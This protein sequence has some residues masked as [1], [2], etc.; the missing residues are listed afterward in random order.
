[1]R[2]VWLLLP[3]L[4]VSFAAPLGGTE[5]GGLIGRRELR[6]PALVLEAQTV[7]SGAAGRRQGVLF[8]T[9]SNFGGRRRLSTPAGSDAAGSVEP[10]SSETSSDDAIASLI[11][12]FGGVIH[13]KRRLDDDDAV[14]EEGDEL[15]AGPA[16]TKDSILSAG[17][18][19]KPS[20][21]DEGEEWMPTYGGGYRKEP[22]LQ[23][24]YKAL[25]SEP[26]FGSSV[27]SSIND[28]AVVAG[29]TRG[30]QD[31]AAGAAST[32]HTDSGAQQEKTP[33]EEATD[34]TAD[35]ED[36]KDKSTKTGDA[37]PTSAKD[38]LPVKLSEI[39]SSVTNSASQT[40][41]K[42]PVPSQGVQDVPKQISVEDDEEY[43]DDE[44]YED[45]EEHVQSNADKEDANKIQGDDSKPASVAPQVNKAP[46]TNAE[47]M[48]Y[49][50]EQKVGVF[51]ATP[52]ISQLTENNQ[53]LVTSSS[54]AVTPPQ[55]GVARA[56]NTEDSQQAKKLIPRIEEPASEQTPTVTNLPL[57]AVSA[58]L[59]A[60]SSVH[61]GMLNAEQIAESLFSQQKEISTGSSS[62]S[63]TKSP[64]LGTS[65]KSDFSNT[66]SPRLSVH[67]VADQ[68]L[69]VSPNNFQQENEQVVSN[70]SALSKAAID[71]SGLQ[72]GVV[73]NSGV[74]S[75]GDTSVTSEKS[76]EDCKD[77]SK[78]NNNNAKE[79]KTIVNV[80]DGSVL[81]RANEQD[82]TSG[83][84]TAVVHSND[85]S[86]QHSFI[87]PVSR[88]AAQ[89]EII[90]ALKLRAGK[91]GSSEQPNTQTEISG[92]KRPVSENSGVISDSPV[93]AA[94]LE[95]ASVPLSMSEKKVS[96]SHQ[97]AQNAVQ[98]AGAALMDHGVPSEVPKE[99]IQL[100]NSEGS[101]ELAVSESLIPGYG[102]PETVGVFYTLENV[103]SQGS[104]P[105]DTASFVAEAPAVRFSK[106]TNE[107]NETKFSE[108]PSNETTPNLS[109]KLAGK[110]GDLQTPGTNSSGQ[111][112]YQMA[113]SLGA[114]V[115]GIEPKSTQ[116]SVP[117]DSSTS[118]VTGTDSL[119]TAKDHKLP[120]NDLAEPI[121]SRPK[122]D[123]HEISINVTDGKTPIDVSG[124]VMT[125]S[126]NYSSTPSR[127]KPSTT[128]TDSTTGLVIEGRDSDAPIDVSGIAT[129][130]DTPADEKKT[131]SQRRT[132]TGGGIETM[133]TSQNE[134][135][136]PSSGSIAST[137]RK[138]DCKD[139]DNS[140]VDKS[141]HGKPVVFEATP[142]MKVTGA[143]SLLAT[144]G[145]VETSERTLGSATGDVYD[146]NITEQND[147][148][149][150]EP[151]ERRPGDLSMPS[152]GEPT[153]NE[154]KTQPK[155]SQGTGT[156]Y[157]VAVTFTPT[158]DD[159]TMTTLSPLTTLNNVVGS[160]KEQ[161][162]SVTS[163]AQVTTP[164]SKPASNE[165]GDRELG[166]ID[167]PEPISSSEEKP[168]GQ[169]IARVVSLMMNT[170][171]SSKHA[172]VPSTIGNS[173][174][175]AAV[176]YTPL[177]IS[178]VSISTVGP[179][180]ATLSALGYE[181]V[182]E[183][184][185]ASEPALAPNLK[186]IPL[187]SPTTSLD[188]KQ[189][190]DRELRN[191]EVAE[192]VANQDSASQATPPNVIEPQSV[193]AAPT[194]TTGIISAG[195]YSLIDVPSSETSTDTSSTPDAAPSEVTSTPASLDVTAAYRTTTT[196]SVEGPVTEATSS[197]STSGALAELSFTQSAPGNLTVS[198]ETPQVSAQEHDAATQFINESKPE[199]GA[200]PAEVPSEVVINSTGATQEN[201]LAENM[202]TNESSP[203]YPPLFSTSE[204]LL[205]G[206]TGTITEDAQG[207]SIEAPSLKPTLVVTNEQVPVSS[208]RGTDEQTLQANV[209]TAKS[210]PPAINESSLTFSSMASDEQGSQENVNTPA[211][212]PAAITEP[213]PPLRLSSAGVQGFQ[214]SLPTPEG[215]TL[216]NPSI[217]TNA[218]ATNKSLPTSLFVPPSSTSVPS[219][220]TENTN[221]VTMQT[222]TENVKESSGTTELASPPDTTVATSTLPTVH[223][224]KRQQVTP[225]LPLKRPIFP[226]R[227][228][229][230]TTAVGQRRLRPSDLVGTDG[231]YVQPTTTTAPTT[232][233][234][235]N[236]ANIPSTNEDEQT[237]HPVIETPNIYLR[238]PHFPR[239]LSA[240]RHA[241]T[242]GKAPGRATGRRRKPGSRGGKRRTTTTP[243]PQDTT[244]VAPLLLED[245]NAGP[246]GIA[247][248]GARI[249]ARVS[250]GPHLL[251][252]MTE[253]PPTSEP[254]TTHGDF[255]RP[256]KARRTKRPKTRPMTRPPGTE[257][258]DV[259]YANRAPG[260]ASTR[261]A[262]DKETAYETTHGAYITDVAPASTTYR[263]KSPLVAEVTLPFTESTGTSALSTVEY[264][265]PLNDQPESSNA[266]DLGQ[267]A[268]LLPHDT[269]V[270][271]QSFDSQLLQNQPDANI[272]SDV[273]KHTAETTITPH[274]P[275]ESLI[276]L[277][278]EATI[279]K[280]KDKSEL[281]ETTSKSTLAS[282]PTSSPT[283][284]YGAKLNFESSAVPGTSGGATRGVSHV[285]YSEPISTDRLST[286]RYKAVTESAQVSP[287]TSA[288]VTS[289]SAKAVYSVPSLSSGTQSSL[290]SVTDS[291]VTD[292]K[293]YPTRYDH[294]HITTSAPTVPPTVGPVFSSSDISAGQSTSAPTANE[295]FIPPTPEIDISRI[296]TTTTPKPTQPPTTQKP[297]YPPLPNQPANPVAVFLVGEPGQDQRNA[298]AQKT[299]PETTRT[300]QHTAVSEN[301]S[302]RVPLQGIQSPETSTISEVPQQSTTRRPE[303][304]VPPSFL[305][306]SNPRQPQSAVFEQI[307]NPGQ[308][309]QPNGATAVTYATATNPQPGTGVNRNQL[310]A[311]IS[312]NAQTSD[313][314]YTTASPQSTNTATPTS[315]ASP[316]GLSAPQQLSNAAT[317]ETRPRPPSYVVD[318][319]QSPLTN[320]PPNAPL[321]TYTLGSLAKQPSAEG[322]PPNEGVS[323][324]PQAQPS[325]PTTKYPISS[326]S[327]LRVPPS[328]VPQPAFLEPLGLQVRPLIL[329]QGP[330]KAQ[331]SQPPKE[332]NYLQSLGLAL[333]K[334][335]LPAFQQPSGPIENT[336]IA[337]AKTQ[338]Q[339]V[340]GLRMPAGPTQQAATSGAAAQPSRPTYND[341]APLR[342]N[343]SQPKLQPNVPQVP[344]TQPAYI[345][346][347]GLQVGYVPEAQG[348]IGSNVG[349]PPRVPQPQVRV[350]QVA[351]PAPSKPAAP[352]R[353]QVAAV[354][355]QPQGVPSG[356]T[357]RRIPQR[358]T[359]QYLVGQPISQNKPV[360]SPA[361][362]RRLPGAES[363]Q[364]FV[365]PSGA[366]AKLGAQRPPVASTPP[367]ASKPS[368]ASAVTQQPAPISV[369]QGPAAPRPHIGQA[370]T[371]IYFSPPVPM[372]RNGSKQ[373]PLPVS[374]FFLSIRHD[375]VVQEN[376][377][378]SVVGNVLSLK[379]TIPD[380]IVLPAQKAQ[381][382]TRAVV[383]PKR[384]NF[385]SETLLQIPQ[386]PR[387][388]RAQTQKG[389]ISAPVPV[390][391]KPSPFPSYTPQSQ[392]PGTVR[393]I[394]LSPATGPIPY[395]PKS[396][397]PASQTL[398]QQGTH[399]VYKV[400]TYVPVASA[401][402]PG[403][404]GLTATSYVPTTPD[405]QVLKVTSVPK[406]VTSTVNQ[407]NQNGVQSVV[408]RAVSS[409]GV[410]GKQKSIS[411]SAAAQLSTGVLAGTTQTQGVSPT[412]V[413]LR[414]GLAQA[415]Q[416][417][418]VQVT[419]YNPQ[420]SPQ[421]QQVQPTYVQQVPVQ[422]AY[423]RG[424]QP[425]LRLQLPV[426]YSAASLPSGQVQ[427]HPSAA[428]LVGQYSP[429]QFQTVYAVPQNVRASESSALR[430]SQP[431][432]VARGNSGLQA[433]NAGTAKVQGFA[434]IVYARPPVTLV[435]RRPYYAFQQPVYV[436]ASA[437]QPAQGAH[438]LTRAGHQVQQPLT[439]SVG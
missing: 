243:P 345:Q 325:A 103:A 10:D 143:S 269:A 385:A 247:E 220:V 17:F 140:S 239:P 355:T 87:D 165:P 198:S 318:Q 326:T 265:E 181:T 268:S 129:S 28:A 307:R 295:E 70:P 155:K 264:D 43:E 275:T 424:Q 283:T 64:D 86:V 97:V 387:P 297:Y 192:S 27:P 200:V 101:S 398:P 285:E 133:K 79:R 245:T 287:V 404:P 425:G 85:Q 340:Q 61:D 329:T 316:S 112:S 236:S 205:P 75:S 197:T 350:P 8:K 423:A 315:K 296:T 342:P 45:E 372:N 436:A 304:G 76:T 336:G 353:P 366:Q 232:N 251:V 59:A 352:R 249:G 337:I 377:P 25:L 73:S 34:K 376:E 188:R 278:N 53:T 94:T 420:G 368:Q 335:Q 258:N 66:V 281:P 1:M 231:N 189:D 381:Q 361:P 63:S 83:I 344:H 263:T 308:L 148:P 110:G 383:V 311:A 384:P 389:K 217:L 62:S 230:F 437:Q 369:P 111:G 215:P 338:A 23:S 80:Q 289:Q 191:G 301:S 331:I 229:S 42:L 180:T 154:S 35:S 393:Q 157:V 327:R 228:P 266:E 429:Q 204:G 224:P 234:Y 98:A 136:G 259:R 237:S 322:F 354:T 89:A 223:V 170:N 309:A 413:L 19:R 356:Q 152:E 46:N 24:N 348:H 210:S 16:G 158:D 92:G 343:L 156:G 160:N 226:T 125:L 292:S 256:V 30:V 250:Q 187:I 22:E 173:V 370:H 435:E 427:Y 373:P 14:S 126:E 176:K 142:N 400:S 141:P 410:S 7:S 324:K 199:L 49:I 306:P 248:F 347:L 279:I 33:S 72:S 20:E 411:P 106:V 113:T 102:S 320:V 74:S 168:A 65:V 116:Q 219:T 433:A 163:E 69:V 312:Y 185:I 56:A 394:I 272:G 120:V 284:S 117:D 206:K 330:T 105:S 184:Q 71:S 271:S 252:P 127:P 211:S 203:A 438:T 2:T 392:Q 227:P 396:V 388:A 397:V 302:S 341:D 15:V 365:A 123:F 57:S 147:A 430:A 238:R 134:T 399:G 405:G 144:D 328:Y 153:V 84:F 128:I 403:R 183:I 9:S 213:S 277:N 349:T 138:D 171:E 122:P 40:S 390:A 253:T 379:K 32:N 254:Q 293:F 207:A 321:K 290:S 130:S 55:D 416:Q 363:G 137:K 280:D 107:Q 11:N 159:E 167:V 52:Q 313:T 273:T 426:F 90:A 186:E 303:L 196:S 294:Q 91:N 418:V 242:R 58:E 276:I 362:A 54:A 412:N 104:V 60:K 37:A 178:S 415:P 359:S 201:A 109:T 67:S 221:V 135:E 212:P 164:S 319:H 310:N 179:S 118:F 216:V 202:S 31:T 100:S 151:L 21:P 380:D 244:T 439:L 3:F 93:Q 13:Q 351:Q 299:V 406:P 260:F 262:V 169:S 131:P 193:T 149:S 428:G 51:G 150:D 99:N 358:G 240:N 334:Y 26:D 417:Q 371:R 431:V 29:S 5:P 44:D 257:Y 177:P 333:S 233:S 6:R 190:T 360:S 414:Q 161:S 409:P 81:V 346:P 317:T 209:P 378:F 270:Q 288:Q 407:A 82:Q 214:E 235:T 18:D 323:T 48:T 95:H 77:N 115:E 47:A 121:S 408:V 146:E 41:A 357:A 222:A 274:I 391:K 182:K 382:P 114:T 255:N 195:H 332:T 367:R 305:I 364:S 401:S 119:S 298:S 172:S 286:E 402:L 422:Q 434:P 39:A 419:S 145:K 339:S 421:F 395:Q 68:L 267:D 78:G 88:E 374:P 96:S 174:L 300:S 108:H 246:S 4:A 314:P 194:T 261:I 282:F 38:A 208:F 432:H 375:Q 291:F 139:D 132:D 124:I 175:S 166:G 12:Q 36:C 225:G 50:G 162:Q 218:E 241:T 386:T